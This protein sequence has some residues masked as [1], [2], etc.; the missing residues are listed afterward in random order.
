MPAANG[1]P[2]CP[3][4]GIAVMPGYP[5][6]PK[7]HAALPASGRMN[8]IADGGGG[9]SAA[10]VVDEPA[11][12]WP[13]YVA[14]VLVLAGAVAVVIIGSGGKKPAAELPDDPVTPED[15]VEPQPGSAA[16]DEGPPAVLP[17]T[18][19]ASP[20]A[21]RLATTMAGLR[22]YATVEPI[23]DTIEIRTA[24]CADA[25]VAGLLADVTADLRT[26]GI[27]TVTCRALHG[28]EAWTRPL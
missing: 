22:L 8:R 1:R 19:D 25:R 2:T 17:R 6:C 18:P 28:A 16:P 13:W 4:C 23:G 5:R 21:D 26:A 10:V 11:R 9:T 7:C 27:T 3:S 24:Y 15:V 14:G 12:R 20:V